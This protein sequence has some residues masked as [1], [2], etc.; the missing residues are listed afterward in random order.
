MGMVLNLSTG[1]PTTSAKRIM[2][3]G[4]EY[5]DYFSFLKYSALPLTDIVFNENFKEEF[6]QNS[7][8]YNDI[9]ARLGDNLSRN[10]FKHLTLFRR[11]YDLRYLEGLEDN[12]LQQYFE[13][14]L[15]LRKE[16]ESF[17]DIGGFDAATTLEFI[18]HSPLYNE[19]YYFEPQQSMFEYSQ[20]VLALH[21]RIH[22]FNI[23]LSNKNGFLSFSPDGSASKVSET[24]HTTIQIDTLDRL[25][26]TPVTFIKMD[27]EGSEAEAL[28]GA[29]QT[30][31]R[32]RPILAISIYHKP[33][34]FWRIP[35]QILEICNDYTLYVRHYTESIYETVMFFVPPERISEAKI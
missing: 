22:Y 5:L 23:G 32:Y 25:I 21:P 30:I 34:D 16:G 33:G 27:I 1:K 35:K 3:A 28:E 24:G 9:F 4:L 12:P 13:P 8:H 11:T 6:V 10:L 15:H 7:H 18:R 31:T 26:D 17:V 2:S 20:N 29:V 14:F 19:I